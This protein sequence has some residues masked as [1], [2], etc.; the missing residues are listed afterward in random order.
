MDHEV[1]EEHEVHE[2][3]RSGKKG[4]WSG[5]DELERAGIAPIRRHIAVKA[6]I[7]IDVKW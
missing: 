7:D 3:E 4:G 2:Q 5:A 6:V 1:H